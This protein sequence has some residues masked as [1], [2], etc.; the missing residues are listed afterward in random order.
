MFDQQLLHQRVKNLFVRVYGKKL[1]FYPFTGPHT[2]H[3]ILGA[4][5]A[6]YQVSRR[7]NAHASSAKSF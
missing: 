4:Q 6:L 5:V 7:K 3:L 2:L 1:L